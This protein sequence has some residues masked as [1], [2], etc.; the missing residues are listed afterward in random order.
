MGLLTMAMKLL[1][2]SRPDVIMKMFRI[3]ISQAG[4][5]WARLVDSLDL[6]SPPPAAPETP[7]GS[8]VEGLPVT[9]QANGREANP[10]ALL[11]GM[12]NRLGRMGVPA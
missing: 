8:G 11:A 4:S 10:E 6:E 12:M 9:G 5:Q 3:T 1:G 7:A 2:D